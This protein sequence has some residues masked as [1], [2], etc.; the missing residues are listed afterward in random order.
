[1]AIINQVVSGGG[2]PTPSGKYQLLQRV[3][4]DSNNEIGA[5]CGYHTD[6]NDVE[7]AVVCLDAAYRLASGQIM[8]TKAAITGLPSY[9]NLSAYS[10]KET[11][12]Y[13]CNKILE[14]CSVSGYTSSAI[15]HCRGQSFIID[16]VEYAGQVP[17]AMELLKVFEH[18]EGINAIDPTSTA[19]PTLI[20]PNATTTWASTQYN[21]QYVSNYF[22]MCTLRGDVTFDNPTVSAFIIPILELPNA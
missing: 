2:S 7:Y 20:I 18:R 17:T 6:A 5:V 22:F 3:T 16:G 8:S 15:T 11:A 12:T 19:N 14:Q 21:N 10:A 4:D 9:S 13:N 1:M